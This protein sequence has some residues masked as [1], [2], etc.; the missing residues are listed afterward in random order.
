MSRADTAERTIAAL[1]G[2]VELLRT[3]TDIDTWDDVLKVAADLPGTHLSH[4]VQAV[5]A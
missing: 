1:G 5:M 4:T 3:L 2:E